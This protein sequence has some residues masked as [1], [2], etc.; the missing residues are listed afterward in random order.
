MDGDVLLV[1]IVSQI[2]FQRNLLLV[3]FIFNFNIVF[4]RFKKNPLI[5]QLSRY[6]PKDIL[7]TFLPELQS[8]QYLIMYGFFTEIKSNNI[9][10]PTLLAKYYGLALAF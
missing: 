6:I 10:K 5:L 1:L 9:K 3:I 2:W 7:K 8:M 4:D